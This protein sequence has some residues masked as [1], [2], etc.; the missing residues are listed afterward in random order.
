MQRIKNGRPHGEGKGRKYKKS[1]S[2][3]NIS[4]LYAYPYIYSTAQ[5]CGFK[6]QI[7]DK[8]SSLTGKTQNSLLRL[9]SSH[10]NLSNHFKI[11]KVFSEKYHEF[12]SVTDKYGRKDEF[13]AIAFR[14]HCYFFC[15]QFS[16]LSSQ[17]CIHCSKE[18]LQPIDHR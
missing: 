9:K 10:G 3:T 14:G 4:D 12:P 1:Q 2:S 11:R 13:I 6:V 7:P 18:L 16:N 17:E 15:I 5:S 8:T